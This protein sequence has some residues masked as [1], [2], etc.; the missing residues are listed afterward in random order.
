MVRY[1]IALCVFM[2]H[3]YTVKELNKTKEY[4]IIALL[5]ADLP[6]AY[7]TSDTETPPRYIID[8]TM[9][10]NVLHKSL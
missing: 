8:L 4:E 2:V 3:Y 5:V 9:V 1:F 7:S 6:P 10:T